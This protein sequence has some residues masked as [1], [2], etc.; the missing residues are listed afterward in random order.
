MDDHADFDSVS[1]RNETASDVSRPTSRE[2]PQETTLPTR[3]ASGKRR[4]SSQQQPHHEAQAGKLAEPVDLGGIGDGILECTVDSPLKENDGTKDAYVSYLITTIV[5]HH[6]C[7]ALLEPSRSTNTLLADR[8]QVLSEARVLHPK[9]VYRLCLF[10]KHPI[11]RISCL[12]SASFTRK[13]QHG[14][15]TRRPLQH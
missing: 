8:L 15:R 2:S 6:F 3:V 5:S 14:L 10:T 12:R 9:T 11:P 4:I 7:P 13:E 1:W